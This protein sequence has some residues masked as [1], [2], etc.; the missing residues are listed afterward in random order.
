ME[1]QWHK[2]IENSTE[3]HFSVRFLICW[4]SRSLEGRHVLRE[5]LEEEVRNQLAPDL[6]LWND[7]FT[8]LDWCAIIYL[9]YNI[10][11]LLRELRNRVW[12]PASRS[13]WCL[14][15]RI[16]Q[17]RGK[18]YGVSAGTGNCVSGRPH[19]AKQWG[20]CFVCRHLGA[21]GLS[22]SWKVGGAF[23]YGVYP[24]PIGAESGWHTFPYFVCL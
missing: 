7:S 5:F 20:L 8:N 22:F 19:C 18:Q 4:K 10:C 2:P 23:D 17:I 14:L 21:G 9:K 6:F 3:V 24:G 13:L 12:S 11:I 16:S 15:G 1:E